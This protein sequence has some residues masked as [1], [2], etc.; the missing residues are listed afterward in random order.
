MK[1]II[2]PVIFI[3]SSICVS[4]AQEKVSANVQFDKTVHNFGDVLLSDGPLTCSF[5]MTNIGKK[6]VVIYS[7][8][9]SCGCTDVSWSKDPVQPGKT[10]VIKATYNNDEGPYPFDKSLSAYISDSGKPVILRLR[11]VAREKQ[12][13]LKML[14]PIRF[15]ALGFK[16]LNVKAGNMEQGRQRS[17]AISVANLSDKPVKLSFADVS[18]QLT[19]KISKNPI[20]AGEVADIEFTVT[21]DRSLWG[22]NYYYFTPVVDGKKSVA[23]GSTDELLSPGGSSVVGIW[24]I[25]KENF[26]D[27]TRD[28]KLRGSRPMFVNNNSSF[29]KV[30]AGKQYDAVYEVTNEGKSTLEF[31]KADF[32]FPGA[33][34]S[35]PLPVID[36]GQKGKIKVHLDTSK[37]PLGEACVIVSLITNSPTRPLVDLFLTGWIE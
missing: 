16:I 26:S 20:P 1:K 21:A 33:T 13:P 24:A 29:G 10:A 17:D 14:Y 22:K 12:L 34:L 15:G 19:L 32:D 23:S 18:Q 35:A 11:G 27:M 36:P 5:T 25:T 6:P 37:M 8:V 30:K 31:Y 3:L 9:T 28:E 7:V 2:F 4:L